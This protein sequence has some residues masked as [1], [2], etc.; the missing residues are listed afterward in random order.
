M[1]SLTNACI[2][3]RNLIRANAEDQR[4]FAATSSQIFPLHTL[5]SALLLQNKK[6]V[7]FFRCYGELC[8][9]FLN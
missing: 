1:N 8:F 9:G 6:F 2:Q 5:P 7:V 4:I 3:P